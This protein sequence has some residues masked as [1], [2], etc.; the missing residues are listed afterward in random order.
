MVRG[1]M[2]VGARPRALPYRPPPAGGRT[3]LGFVGQTTYF[4]ACAL[5]DEHPLLAT[6]FIEF[7]AGGDAAALHAELD[8]FAPHVVVVFRPEIVPEG[9]F[10]DLRAATVGFLTEP[11]PRSDD[12]RAHPDLQRRLFELSQVDRSNFDRVI[13][14]DPLIAATSER[15]GLSVWRSL[16][17]PVADHFFAPARRIQAPPRLLFAARGTRH[18]LKL[19]RPLQQ[20]FDVLHVS[21]GFVDSE[22]DA[23]IRAHDV[24]I[25]LHNEPYPS[26]ENR[27]SIYLAAGMLVISEP[28][29]P[30]HGLEPGIDF[31]EATSGEDLVAHVQRLHAFPGVYDRVCARGRRKAEAFR[32]SHVYPRLVADLWADLAAFGTTRT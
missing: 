20:R 19:L 3:R 22:F 28:L 25:N 16:P 2:A 26:Y 6:R 32:A 12:R 5:A 4:A 24:G 17:L 23:L 18:R 10:A 21:F 27:V 29:S 11:I 8:A 9:A 7:R 30:E 14:F 15:V 13:S 31:L 1:A